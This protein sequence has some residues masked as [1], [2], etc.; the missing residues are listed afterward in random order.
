MKSKKILSTGVRKIVNVSLTQVK[1]VAK[2]SPKASKFFVETLLN[3][4]QTDAAAIANNRH[5]T[6][7]LQNY[8]DAV[9]ILHQRKQI[10]DFK[11][12]P[13]ISI[14]VP[15]YNTNLNFLTDCIESVQSQ[16][17]D[18]WELI[19]VDD[20]SP[21][22]EVREL[23]LKFAKVD[24]RIKY[25]F[26][27]ENGHISNA[28]ND[29]LEL[30]RGVFIALLDH[31]DVLW[32]NALYESVKALNKDSSIDFL[33]SDEDKITVNKW[34]HKD[35]F[36]KPDWN[37][38]FLE[39]V[40]YITHFSVIRTSVVREIGGFRSQ[41]D[42]AQDWDL[43]LRISNITDK[44]YHV[45][46]VVYS[47]R[48][49][50][51]SAASGI[52]AKPYAIEAQRL[53]VQES[54]KEK[55]YKNAVVKPGMG[56]DIWTVEHPVIG[57]PK[58]SIVIPTINQPEIL[59]K[60]INSIL[61]N[62]T[63]KNFEIILVDTGST[64]K[65]VLKWYKR[66]ESKNNIKI[67]S[68]PKKP[69]SYS[70]ACNHGASHA[71]G[72]FIV[73]LNND[74]ELITPKWLEIMLGDAQRDDVG[75]VGCR[76][77]YPGGIKIQHAGIGVGLNRTAANLL[78][79]VSK[80]NMTLIQLLYSNTR[81]ELSAVTAACAMIKKDRFNKVGGFTEEFRVTYND[82]DLCLK[83]REAGYRNIYNPQAQLIHHESISIGL[84]KDLPEAKK[85]KQN[86]RD[87]AEL[88][89]TTALLRTTWH[90]YIEHDP[91]VNANIDKRDAFL[92]PKIAS[93]DESIG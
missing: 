41:Y 55:G 16:S 39:S 69:F 78:S 13:L 29:A 60:C 27:K 30:A 84:P 37:P 45:S 53:A 68:W 64:D 67:L 70:L 52:E 26:R 92:E 59:K 6:W 83:L 81:H 38:E 76:L 89:R 17:Y 43:F 61:K 54:L 34:E 32:P 25:H 5:Q 80:N 51:T 86:K 2:K 93:P 22:A 44:I 47:W 20:A 19:L 71:S 49:S 9:D 63:Y 33:Y 50:E 35:I 65:Q 57:N 4:I 40:N 58:V 75:A 3:Y 15:T 88:E 31:D 72:E 79:N 73:F 14:L 36:L 82:V 23:I 28:T 91:H 77:F 12:L 11:Y 87:N 66:I 1:K 46:K 90:K 42:G 7:I 24:K 18:N 62:T 21:K 56:P 10:D 8:P 48:I 74:I 85:S